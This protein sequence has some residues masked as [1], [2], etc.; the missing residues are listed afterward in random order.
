[1][2]HCT[3]NINIYHLENRVREIMCIVN[4]LVDTEKNYFYFL[5]ILDTLYIQTFE[6]RIEAKKPI[7]SQDEIKKLFGNG[8][9]N[10]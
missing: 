4:E 1:M 3:I 10:I 9:F 8:K 7:V 6:S 5:E 2:Y